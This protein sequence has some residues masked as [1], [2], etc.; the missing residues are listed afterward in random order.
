MNYQKLVGNA[1]DN[2]GLTQDEAHAVF[3]YTTKLFYRDLNGAL[4]AGGN[5]DAMALSDLINSGLGKMPASGTTQ[6]RGWRLNTPDDMAAF[7]GKFAL[8]NNVTTKGYWSTAPNEADAYL[9]DR[10]VVMTTEPGA[11]RDIS[12]LSFGVNFHATIGKPIYSSETILPP[13][14]TLKVVDI[15]ANGRLVLEQQ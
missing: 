15:D 7:D 13:G 5:S 12:D 9:A 10:N 3:G 14:V 4:E 11:A 8:G 2:Y 1:V 6:F